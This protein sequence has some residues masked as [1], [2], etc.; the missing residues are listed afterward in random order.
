MERQTRE[1]WAQRVERFRRSGLT[2]REFAAREQVHARTLAWYRWKLG[3]K[4]ERPRS[5]AVRP[6]VAKPTVEFVE[7]VS[8]GSVQAEPFEVEMHGGWRLRVPAGFEAGALERLLGVLE[9]R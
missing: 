5:G 8:S 1:A 4:T 3:C 6:L 9:G 2:I 7:L